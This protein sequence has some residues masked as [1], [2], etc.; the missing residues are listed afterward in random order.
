MVA[1]LISFFVVYLCFSFFMV[2][3]QINGVNRLVTS[4]PL[5]LFETAI[6]L[7]N[8]DEEN[9]PYFDKE[10]LEDNLT[11]YF[12]FHMPRYVDGYDISFY[13]YNI[14]DHSF[15]LDDECQAV[16]VT[17]ETTLIMFKHYQKTMFYEIRS[18]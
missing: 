5:S 18:N 14:T 15:D 11:S 17:I 10:I 9:G 16:E 12:D 7:Y 1:M 2:S 8:I 4:T 13:Y 3:Y 6:V